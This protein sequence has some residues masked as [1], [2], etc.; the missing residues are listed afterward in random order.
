MIALNQAK[1]KD[2]L[3]ALILLSTSGDD[4]NDSLLH[5]DHWKQWFLPELQ[6][7][8][9]NLLPTLINISS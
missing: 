3:P 2:R 8:K 4:V 7:P 6:I 9:G 5:S 1:M